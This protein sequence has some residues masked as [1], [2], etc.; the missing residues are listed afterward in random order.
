MQQLIVSIADATDITSFKNSL[1]N[2]KGV[3]SVESVIP[4]IHPDWKNRLHLP[5]PPLTDA[6]LEELAE[7]MNNETEFYTMEESREITDK[8]IDEWQKSPGYKFK[9]GTC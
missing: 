6:E 4:D 1:M 3:E 8:M 5:G 7:D 2:M 9:K